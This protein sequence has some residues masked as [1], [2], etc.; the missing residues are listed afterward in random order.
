[1]SV[2]TL[3]NPHIKELVGL[4]SELKDIGSTIALLSWDQETYITPRGALSRARQLETLSGI[5]HQH[6][7]AKKLGTLLSTLREDVQTKPTQFSAHDKALVQEMYREYIIATKLPE[8]LVKALSKESS[9][10]LEAWKHARIQNDFKLYEANLAHMVELKREVANTLGFSDSPYDALLDEFENGLTKK[11]VTRVFDVLKPELKKLI[12]LLAH[13]TAAFHH[14][15][16]TSAYDE[17]KLWDLSL[18]VLTAIGFDLERGRQDKSTHP[19]T[20]GLDNSDVRLTTRILTTNPISTLMSSIHEGGHG[21][22]EQ[23]ISPEITHTTLGYVNSLVAHESQSRFWENMIGKSKDF[24]K[25][26]FPKMQSVFPEHLLNSSAEKAWEEVNVV[27]PSLIRVDADEVSYHMHIIIR[28]EIETELIE[29]TL[30]ATDVP[31]R[32]RAAYKEYLGVHVP[33]DAQ[34]PLQDIHWSQ[35]LMGYFPTYSLGSLFAAQLFATLKKQKPRIEENILEG[36]FEYPLHWL[37]EN[38][39]QHGRLYSSSQLCE[40]IT[41]LPLSSD[42]YLQHIREKFNV[43]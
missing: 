4:S 9:L 17:K 21:M 29:G 42:S 13:K 36:K 1:M 22:Y 37:N 39:H 5:Y 28:T 27:Q 38:M 12:P 31:E 3:T 25:Y 30:K 43:Q 35:G 24:W 18:E 14:G 20:M 10:G 8:T 33:D 41:G 11:E 19:F 6:G 2:F 40:R 26:F 7:T 15:L 32:W 23:G 16:F 34:G